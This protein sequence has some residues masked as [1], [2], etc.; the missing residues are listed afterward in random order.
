MADLGFF[1]GQRVE[2]V[3]GR[4]VIMSPVGAAHYT[5]VKLVEEALERA[6]GAGYVV[7]TRAPLL[8]PD[9]SEPEPDAAVVP[10]HPRDYRAAHPSRALLVVEV[11][12]STLAYDRTTKASLYAAA[13]VPE[14]WVPNLVDRR[15]EVHRDPASLPGEAFGAGYRTLSLYLPGDTVPPAGGRAP[16]PVDDLLP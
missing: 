6:Y 9:D 5:G 8:A 10:G 3:G 12:D 13:D 14:Y 11:A 16:V 15:L 1:N 4:I 7:R 2:L